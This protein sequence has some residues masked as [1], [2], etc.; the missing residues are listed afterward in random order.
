MNKIQASDL[1]PGDVLLYAPSSF[2]GYAISWLTAG[3][4]SHIEIYKG[5]G[6][7]YASR[8]GVGVNEYQLRIDGLARVLRSRKPLN[9]GAM[10]V[11]FKA[12][13]GHRYDFGTIKKFLTFGL[14]GGRTNAEVCSELAA[15][16]LR[17]GGLHGLF[18]ACSP[19]EVSPRDF[20]K[21]SSDMLFTVW[22]A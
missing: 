10:A 8:D 11:G 1:L 14:S 20:E 19:D 2:F 21:V 15:Y 9:M 22:Q 4:V 12:K 7:A 16:L 17:I 18:G 13:Q 6:I 5:G 3:W